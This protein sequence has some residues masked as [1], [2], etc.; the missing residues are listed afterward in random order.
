MST[1]CC[2]WWWWINEAA[3]IHL[4]TFPARKI[5][6]RSYH[7]HRI[8]VI[9]VVIFTTINPPISPSSPPLISSLSPPPISSS[10]LSP[11]LQAHESTCSFVPLFAE[12]VLPLPHFSTPTRFTL[13]SPLNLQEIF[14]FASSSS[15]N[16]R[17]CST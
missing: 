13:K 16:N 8:I 5:S 14:S 6:H 2:C 11:P 12:L 17:Q 3:S 4:I 1:E 15:E 9:K 7:H 10:S